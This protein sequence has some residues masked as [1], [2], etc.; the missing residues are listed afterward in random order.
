MQA[1]S[2]DA[3]EGELEAN[4]YHRTSRLLEGLREAAKAEDPAAALEQ[5]LPLARQADPCDGAYSTALGGIISGLRSGSEDLRDEAEGMLSNLIDD[6]E[7]E[8]WQQEHE[9]AM[10]G[11]R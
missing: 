11:W 1:Y 7:V 3:Y 8:T 2:V 6:V 5:C 10:A 4:G 9:A